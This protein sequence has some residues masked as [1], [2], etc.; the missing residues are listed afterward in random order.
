MQHQLNG[1]E[2]RQQPIRS[3]APFLI[4][5]LIRKASVSH[6]AIVDFV[7]SAAQRTLLAHNGRPPTP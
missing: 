7:A 6:E 3:F 2:L 5:D 4:V 1:L